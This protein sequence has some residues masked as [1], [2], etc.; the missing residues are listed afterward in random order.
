MTPVLPPPPP[1]PQISSRL[2][3]QLQGINQRNRDRRR[4]TN[5][6]IAQGPRVSQQATERAERAVAEAQA[7]RAAAA[8]ENLRLKKVRALR[9]RGRALPAQRPAVTKLVMWDLQTQRVTGNKQAY[10][11][12]AIK[13]NIYVKQT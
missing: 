11:T 5:S 6:R 9:R 13:I 3:G 8:K 2:A 12:N 7:A 10:I 4:L 1:P